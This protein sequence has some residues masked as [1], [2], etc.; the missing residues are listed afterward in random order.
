MSADVALVKCCW[1]YLARGSGGSSGLVASSAP[2]QRE[3]SLSR[4]WTV[5]VLAARMEIYDDHVWQSFADAA[6]A[7]AV[8]AAP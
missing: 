5:S 7:L 4:H 2:G 3:L 6:S 1:L 8:P